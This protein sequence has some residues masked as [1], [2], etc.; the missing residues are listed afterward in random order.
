ML[1]VA[2]ELAVVVS[3][4]LLGVQ[5]AEVPLVAG[6]QVET[7]SDD[8]AH[9]QIGDTH[10]DE[11]EVHSSSRVQ[12][13]FGLSCH[14]RTR[15]CA[16]AERN[17]DCVHRVFATGANWNRR[18]ILH[19]CGVISEAIGSS[20]DLCLL[21]AGWELVHPLYLFIVVLVLTQIVEVEVFKHSL[22][23]FHP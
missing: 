16:L 9:Q 17:R 2:G 1:V 13:K 5:L 14:Y 4:T 18:A 12:K 20:M 21:D 15:R 3:R 6:I 19:L 23:L 10:F 11:D 22:H 7:I 8:E